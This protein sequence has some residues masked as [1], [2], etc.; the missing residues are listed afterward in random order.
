MVSQVNPGWLKFGTFVALL[1]LILFQAAGF[2]RPIKSERSIGLGFGVGVGVLYSV[3]TISGPPLAVML[4]NQ[5]LT[6]RDFRA[7]LG[8]IRLAESSFTAV[9][10]AW[11]G[12]YRWKASKLIPYHRAQHRDG[13]ADRRGDHPADP[14]GNVPPGL[15]EL[16]R[17]DRR[18]RALEPAEGAADRRERTWRFSSWWQWRCSTPGCSTV[19]S[20]C[21]CRRSNRPKS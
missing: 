12:L 19:S 18:L 4:S 6:K 5:G 13:R 20:L 14:P 8:F 1:P 3:T 15:H 9:A 2:R 7:A 10:Y 21:S 11:A 17:V 16:R